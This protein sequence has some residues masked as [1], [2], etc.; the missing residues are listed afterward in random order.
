[1]A[2][3]LKKNHINLVFAP[4]VDLDKGSPVI[5]KLE[6]SYGKNP[7][8]VI[9]YARVFIEE[10]EKQNIQTCLKH[11]SGHSD[12]DTHKN[13]VIKKNWNKTEL[14]PYQKLTAPY[15]MISHTINP[16]FDSQLPETFSK[17]AIHYL[18]NNLNFKGEVIT[19]DLCMQ[20]IREDYSLE[21]TIKKNIN[22]GCNILLFSF[23]NSSGNKRKKINYCAQDVERV[24]QNLQNM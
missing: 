6:R 8:T 12:G 18:R 4:C 5:S 2:T 17:K 1:M 19:D 11:F 20:A 14:I 13:F 15:I 16:F 24:L 21:E 7:K 9:K 10:F 3:L 22:A 23:I